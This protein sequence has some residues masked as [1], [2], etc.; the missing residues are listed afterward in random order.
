MDEEEYLQIEEDDLED[1]DN[2]K[3]NQ[4]SS[5]A[6]KGKEVMEKWIGKLKPDTS[7]VPSII[8]S[9]DSY[10]FGEENYSLQ[11][12][13]FYE[14]AEED[15]ETIKT[16]EILDRICRD[17]MFMLTEKTEIQVRVA[18][19]GDHS[20]IPNVMDEFEDNGNARPSKNTSHFPIP[21]QVKMRGIYLLTHVYPQQ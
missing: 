11:S 12:D 14:E 9:E 5:F 20:N 18:T 7:N 1:E 19:V 2:P 6:R 16:R 3:N 21:E 15:M 10:I 17:K 4:T 13:T 8:N